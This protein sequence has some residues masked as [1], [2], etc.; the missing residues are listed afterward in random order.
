MN[1]VY[2]NG[3]RL[4]VHGAIIGCIFNQRCFLTCTVETGIEEI[5][6]GIRVDMRIGKNEG[7][8]FLPFAIETE[9]FE[10]KIFPVKHSSVLARIIS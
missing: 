3:I 9:K 8:L 7:E 5:S 4:V 10:K 2:S 6:D 1:T